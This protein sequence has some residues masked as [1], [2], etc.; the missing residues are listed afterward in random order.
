MNDRD[1]ALGKAGAVR[2]GGCA[3][4]ELGLDEVLVARTRRLVGSVAAGLRLPDGLA[5][6]LVLGASELA[7]N[8]W[9]HGGGQV[10]VEDGRPVAGLPEVWVYARGTAPRELVVSVFDTGEWAEATTDVPAIGVPDPAAEHGRGLQ[11]VAGL[12]AGAGGRWGRHLSRSRLGRREGVHVGGMQLGHRASSEH[13]A[14]E[15]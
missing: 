6:D 5:G 14:V 13:R 15:R 7:T 12:A 4:W 10:V 2:A 9:L 11:I 8:V 3:A 1:D